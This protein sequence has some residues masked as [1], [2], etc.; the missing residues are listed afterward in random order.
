[1]TTRLKILSPG[2]L[3]SV[4]DFGRS[5]YSGDGVPRSGA[6]DP[7]AMRIANALV[8][9]EQACPVIEF[10]Y[11]GPKVTVTGGS[12]RLGL[13]SQAGGTVMRAATQETETV[14]PWQSITLY[15]NDIL[16]ILPLQGEAS[17]YLSIEGGMDIAPVLGSA[18]TY[19]RAGLGGVDGQPLR[20]D[21]EIA[22]KKQAAA[23]QPERIVSTPFEREAGRFRVI[24][25]PQDDYFA[26]EVL[27]SFCDQPYRVSKDA[28]RMG[29]RLEGTSLT[30]LAEKGSDI[31]SDGLLPGSIQVPGNGQPIILFA[32]CQTLGGYP[33][34]ATVISADYHRLGQVLPGDDIVFQVVSLEQAQDLR[35]DLEKQ[36]LRSIRSIKDFYGEGAID[37]KALYDEN[38][39]GGAVDALNPGHFPG[40]LEDDA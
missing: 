15:E 32:D 17:G 2:M 36:V 3:S 38:L 5:G 18:A 20:A 30:H 4:Q 35:R 39:I 37:L 27:N 14:K 23:V 7:V 29:I 34:I 40:H 31:I 24:L 13:G 10:R 1:M 26:P 21:Q 6:A 19:A 12:M 11:M 9:N 8:G 28:D 16:S 33:K 25:G 22:L